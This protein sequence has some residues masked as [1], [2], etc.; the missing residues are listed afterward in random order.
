MVGITTS[1]TAMWQTPSSVGAISVIFN[2]AFA[3]LKIVV[4]LLGGAFALIADGIESLTDSLSSFIVWSGLRFSERA[5]DSDHPYGH[6]KAESLA[7]FVASISLGLSAIFI[8]WQSI[9]E[10][11]NPQSDPAWFTLPF[12]LAVIVGKEILFR[13][14]RT[15]AKHFNSEALRIEA[16]HHRM[17]SLTTLAVFVGILLAI[18]GGPKFA[19]ADDVAALL[20]SGYI[21]FNAYRLSRPSI[22]ALLDKDTANLQR[23]EILSLALSVQGIRAIESMR[24]TRS[25]TGYILDI[26]LEVDGAIPVREGHRIAHL[27]R[28]RLLAEPSLRITHVHTHIEPHER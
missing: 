28:D 20:I 22:D 2:I 1:T 3:V 5:A 6:G 27:L 14:I 15:K 18:V 16:W 12:A 13:F 9:K 10:M 23:E 7:A 11:A 17:D 26:H 19:V 24:M 8:A 21:F 4:G 25:G